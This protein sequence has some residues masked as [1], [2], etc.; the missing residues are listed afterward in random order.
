LARKK[1]DLLELM[2]MPGRRRDEDIAR[3][4][5]T[6]RLEQIVRAIRGRPNKTRDAAKTDDV[7]ESFPV[8][9]DVICT[10]LAAEIGCDAEAL[11]EALSLPS[12]QAFVRQDIADQTYW[13]HFYLSSSEMEKLPDSAHVRLARF[14]GERSG[15]YLELF[16]LP[17]EHGS[18]HDVWSP[19]RIFASARAHDRQGEVHAR[20]LLLAARE[21]AGDTDSELTLFCEAVGVALRKM[22]P[23]EHAVLTKRLTLPRDAPERSWF[24]LSRDCEM[25]GSVPLTKE[26]F[27]VAIREFLR[28]YD[29]AMAAHL[30]MTNQNVSLSTS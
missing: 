3:Q 5:Q 11:R 27:K 19:P 2:M 4:E 10:D 30:E 29:A 24:R 6:T 16:W 21:N 22:R 7:E 1:I 14:I 26:V 8:P 28:E 20:K 18:G 13:G 23:I 17:N 25:G 9:N 12:V 15:D